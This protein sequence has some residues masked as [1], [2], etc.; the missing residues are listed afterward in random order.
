[1]NEFYLVNDL[2][3]IIDGYN[4]E[5]VQK[6]FSYA[7]KAAERNGESVNAYVKRIILEDIERSGF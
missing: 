6:L 5:G 3:E 7:L 2:N 1:M 4:L